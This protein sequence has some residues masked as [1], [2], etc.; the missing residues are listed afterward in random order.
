MKRVIENGD[1]TFFLTVSYLEEFDFLLYALMSS[2]SRDVTAHAG[3]P[4]RGEYR[5]FEVIRR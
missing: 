3:L 1:L 5:L 2:N 4:A